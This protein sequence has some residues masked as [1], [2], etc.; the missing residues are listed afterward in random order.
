MSL[1]GTKTGSLQVMANCAGI[2]TN[3]T[4]AF[5]GSGGPA[6]GVTAPAALAGTVSA[7]SSGQLSVTDPNTLIQDGQLV[8]IF[9]YVAGVLNACFN[10]TVSNVVASAGVDTVTLTGG[11][12][13]P[14][15]GKYWAASG[16]APTQLPANSTV[17][18]FAIAQQITDGVSITGNNIVQL[19]ATSTQP[20]IIDWWKGSSTEER[21]SGIPASGQFDAWPESAGITAPPAGW[22]GTDIVNTINC[23]NA[24]SSAAVMQAAVILT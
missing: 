22:A 2:S 17:I 24:G 12:A 21:V 6:W 5:S 18:S 20:G 4:L 23:Y 7:V 10:C 15:G 19:L 13:T 16:S 11:S 3:Q 14:T 8:A 9:W 1:S